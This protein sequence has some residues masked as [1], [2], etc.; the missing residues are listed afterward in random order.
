MAK[1]YPQLE[2]NYPQL[3]RNLTHACC[4]N[5]PNCMQL[6]EARPCSEHADCAMHASCLSISSSCTGQIVLSH[7]Q[8]TGTNSLFKL[9]SKRPHTVLPRFRN[10]CRT[11]GPQIVKYAVQICIGPWISKVHLLKHLSIRQ[12]IIDQRL[13]PAN[14]ESSA[15]AMNESKVTKSPVLRPQGSDWSNGLF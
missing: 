5:S 10:P 7:Q 12:L 6:F 9:M 4:S 15:L 1:P 11:A 2:R 13:C 14:H 8:T 3:E